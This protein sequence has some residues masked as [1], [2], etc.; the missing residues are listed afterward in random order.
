MSIKINNKI[1]SIPPY[2]STHWSR[3]SGMY[4]KGSTL[5]LMMNQGELI[6]IPDLSKEIL[7]QIFQAH[8]A[9]LD[10]ESSS[11]SLACE[12]PGLKSLFGQMADTSIRLAVSSL[13][14]LETISQHNPDQSDAPDLPQELLVKL[15]TFSELVPPGKEL[16]LPKAE[17]FCNCFHCQVTR[18]LH[19]ET[20][21]VKEELI[22][23]VADQELEFQQWN[24]TQIGNHLYTVSNKLETQEAYQVYLG[25]P[26]GCTCGK[27][28]NDGCEHIVAVL[29]S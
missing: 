6:S 3:V 15:G 4:M 29:R 5:S 13:D 8:A 10:Q 22:E 14:G 11:T 23:L 17:P 20:I 18:A 28:G 12:T 7:Q 25:H 27:G 19:H 2:I 9:Y 24:I 16:I 1:I 21:A 26:V